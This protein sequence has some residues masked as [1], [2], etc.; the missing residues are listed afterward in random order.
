MA[1]SE[2]NDIS[3]NNLEDMKNVTTVIRGVEKRASVVDAATGFNQVC[4]KNCFTL[5]L[6]ILIYV[7][8]GHFTFF[9]LCFVLRVTSS[10]PILKR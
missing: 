1:S 4:H 3:Y 8:C 2:N 7:F 10:I 5:V 9:S 6:T